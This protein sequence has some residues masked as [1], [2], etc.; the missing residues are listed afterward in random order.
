[1]IKILKFHCNFSSEIF[2][3]KQDSPSSS[4]ALVVGVAVGAAVVVVVVV[5]GLVVDL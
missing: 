3:H 2:T 4:A 5:V 1:M